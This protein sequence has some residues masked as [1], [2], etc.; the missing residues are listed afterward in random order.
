VVVAQHGH[1]LLGLGGLREGGEAAQVE[2][3]HRDLAPVALERVVGVA[4]EDQLGEL[5]REEALQPPQT[6]ELADLVGHPLLERLVQDGQL[7]AGHLQL[8]GA[9]PHPLLG[10]GQR[11]PQIVGGLGEQPELDLLLLA[12][13]V[14][15]EDRPLA[16]PLD[17]DQDVEEL[18][19]GGRVLDEPGDGG[20]Q[21]AEIVLHRIRSL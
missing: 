17:A 20:S 11:F 3:H 2:E 4:G 5:G 18:L 7:V 13:P 21:D 14:G 16:G 12:R 8:G 10:L 6:I 9:L 15:A 1:D 19:P